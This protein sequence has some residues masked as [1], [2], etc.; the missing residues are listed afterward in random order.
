MIFAVFLDLDAWG[1]R[2]QKQQRG[3]SV[4]DPLH[5]FWRFMRGRVV[6]D[7]RALAGQMRTQPR[8]QSGAEQLGIGTGH[9]KGKVPQILVRYG[10]RSVFR[11]DS[12]LTV[13]GAHPKIR[14]ID[15]SE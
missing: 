9:L 2:W 5:R 10:R 1:I 4:F 13:L 14:A 11:A 15:R 8:F 12:R 7:T 3:T 6:Q